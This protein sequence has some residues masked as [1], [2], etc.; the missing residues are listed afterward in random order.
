MLGEPAKRGTGEAFFF[1]RV[2]Q[3]ATQKRAQLRI[4]AGLASRMRGPSPFSP[5]SANKA[6]PAPVTPN[7]RW[8]PRKLGGVARLKVRPRAERP[9]AWASAPRR[10]VPSGPRRRHYATTCCRAGQKLSFRRTRHRGGD[11]DPEHRSR[12]GVAATQGVDAASERDLD[13][14]LLVTLSISAARA[15]SSFARSGNSTSP[16]PS[17]S[18]RRPG[19]P[20]PQPSPRELPMIPS[21]RYGCDLLVTRHLRCL[22]HGTA[23]F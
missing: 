18:A 10:T 9:T 16:P 7:L 3:V 22:D 1:P 11:S 23:Y 12:M 15:A 17:R 5:L 13:Q 14:R 19:H 6:Q 2:P 4:R 21:D 20:A 8:N